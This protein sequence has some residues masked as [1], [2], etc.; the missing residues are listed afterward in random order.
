MKKQHI[1]VIALILGVAL[2]FGT[3]ETSKSREL[4]SVYARLESGQWILVTPQTEEEYR[5]ESD[6]DICKAEFTSDPNL[7]GSTMVQVI[8]DDGVYVPQ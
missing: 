4:N 5:C 6:D 8:E 7:P 3:A 1:G 2:A